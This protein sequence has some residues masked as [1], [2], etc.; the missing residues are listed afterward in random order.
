MLTAADTW[1]SGATFSPCRRYRYRLWRE[2]GDPTQRCAFIMC[3]PSVGDECEDD[4][5]I[6]RC[7]GF[8]KRWGFG[9]IDLANLFAWV[10]TNPLG[11]LEPLDPV[12]PDNNGHLTSVAS[13]AGR[14]VMA[15]GAHGAIRA[16]LDLRAHDVATM[17]Q[18]LVKQP[19][20]LGTLGR[21]ADGYP[22]HPARIPNF[23]SFVDHQVVGGEKV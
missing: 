15:W 16:L 18:L 9:A 3:N 20:D 19:R 1:K 17:L 2:W 13:N 8:A 12:G 22:R 14:V 10:S 11:L 23:T 7:I 5:T 4:H 6:R 21:T